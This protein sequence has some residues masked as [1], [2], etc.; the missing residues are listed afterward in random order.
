MDTKK[1]KTYEINDLISW[2]EGEEL[3]ISPKYQRNPV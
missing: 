3:N 1:S 2:Y